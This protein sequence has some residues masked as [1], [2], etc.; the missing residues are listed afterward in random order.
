MSLALILA[1]SFASDLIA[2][3]LERVFFFNPFIIIIIIKVDILVVS[4]LFSGGG[5]GGGCLT[6]C[7]MQ[8][9]HSLR[10]RFS[11]SWKLSAS[12]LPLL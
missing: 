11:C 10:Y 12:N 7:F 2:I 6:R 1:F 5:G 3:M 8:P 4:L 9:F